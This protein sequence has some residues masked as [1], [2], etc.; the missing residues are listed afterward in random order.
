[1]EFLHSHKC[2]HRDLAARNVLVGKEGVVKIANYGLVSDMS[3]NDYY[4]MVAEGK[5]P[6]KWMS[7][8]SIFERVHTHM[9]RQGG[10]VSSIVSFCSLTFGHLVF[11]CGRYSPGGT[12][13]TRMCLAWMFSCS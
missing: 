7:P 1:M 2:L 6:V 3:D 13:P 4:R 11:C 10:Q 12:V 5:L 8:E 9:V